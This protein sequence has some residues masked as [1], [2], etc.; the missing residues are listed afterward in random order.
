MAE[1][2]ARGGTGSARRM[3]SALRR[4]FSSGWPLYAIIVLY[5]VAS[6]AVLWHHEPWRD[7]AQAWLIARD[8]PGI[9]ALVWVMGYEGT[10]ALWHVLLLP[11]AK[12]GFPFWSMQA[13][14][15]LIALAGVAL[16]TLYSPFSKLEK[17]VF[18]FGYFIFFEYC[19]IARSYV[20]AVFLLFAIA[21]LY[22]QRYSR[23][24]A[25]CALVSL[26]ANVA[27]HGTAIAAA[28][29]VAFVLEAALSRGLKGLAGIALPALL[30][31]AGFAVAVYQVLPPPDLQWWA[32]LWNEELSE[33]HLK[34]IPA[35]MINAFLPVSDDR[36]GFWGSNPQLPMILGT[37]YW[38]A[39][40]PALL[41]LSALFLA[42]S[43]WALAIF[44]LASVGLLSI[45]FLKHF[46]YYRQHGLLFASFI[47]AVWVARVDSGP[48]LLR[49]AF[50]DKIFS[51]SIGRYANIALSLLLVLL[52][53]IQAWGAAIA[54]YYDWN[55]DFS[56]SKKSTQFLVEN[57]LTGTGTLVAAYPSAFAGTILAYM[58]RDFRIYQLE[59]GAFGSYMVWNTTLE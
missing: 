59:Y 46:G 7:E 10:P 20:L 1:K 24:F 38:W 25:Y 48:P 4:F 18:P 45:F 49:L 33:G 52:L 43:R 19:V 42:R 5:A 37:P 34:N 41:L 30:L 50:L 40:I 8:V 54:A 13:L 12:L 14:H 6:L 21:A 23:P 3:L 27:V 47:F 29:A 44:L 31:L 53:A 15:W 17:L 58:G 28:I 22:R 2:P 55:Y 56:A 32:T 57:N 35:V 36:P 26:L 39:P 11:L 9:G 16:F 51:G